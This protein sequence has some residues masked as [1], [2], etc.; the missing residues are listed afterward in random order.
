MKTLLNPCWLAAPILLLL[1]L[2]LGGCPQPQRRD[3]ATQTLPKRFGRRLALAVDLPADYVLNSEH[4][5]V[6]EVHH[7]WR[8]N[9]RSLNKDANLGIYI[10]PIALPYCKSG[11]ALTPQTQGLFGAASYRCAKCLRWRKCSTA[12]GEQVALET[13]I[14]GGKQWVVQLFILGE[15]QQELERLR[16][17]GETLRFR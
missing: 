3:T 4:G 1:L 8:R 6:F 14:R 5:E 12:V 11:Q 17:I 2:I 13:F 16:R 7:I 9:P 15:K 10:G